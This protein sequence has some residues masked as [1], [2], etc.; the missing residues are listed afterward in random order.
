MPSQVLEDLRESAMRTRLLTQV[1]SFH[2]LAHS[3]A[4]NKNST[5]SFSNVS[6]LFAQNHPGGAAF[7][8]V[9]SLLMK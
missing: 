5:P 9:R 7:P 4:L 3:F 2:T 6:A 1:L 8:R